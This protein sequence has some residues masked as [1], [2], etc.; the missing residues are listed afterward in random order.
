[1]ILRAAIPA[2]VPSLLGFIRLLAA[3]EREPDAVEMTEEQLE[4][5]LFGPSPRAEALIVELD[6]TPRGAAFWF[7]SFNTWTGRPGLYVEDVYV[8][9]AYRDR[10]IG[11]AIFKHLADL[12]VT[13]GYSRMEWSVL[14]W[15]EPAIKFYQNLGAVAQTEWHKYRLSGAALAAVAGTTEILGAEHG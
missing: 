15:N 6:G 7:Q 9:E 14:D 5:A 12:A 8:E 11:R 4:D 3:Y 1:V 13:R 2:D 10:G